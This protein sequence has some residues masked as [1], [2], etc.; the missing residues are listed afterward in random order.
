MNAYRIYKPNKQGN[1]SASEW[2][3]S[4][5]REEKFSPWKLFFSIAKQTGTDENGNNRFDWDNAI[6]V[7]MDV[8]DLCEILAVLED[9]QKEA[10][11]GGKIFHQYGNA[12]KIINFI[13]NEENNN[14]FIKVSHQNNGNVVS[15]QH[16][17]SIGEGCALKVLIEE[18]II[19]LTNWGYNNYRKNYT[20]KQMPSVP[21]ES[22]QNTLQQAI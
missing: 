20:P 2:Q 11:N 18:A 12:N 17:L 21:K 19:K 7:K 8:N 1:G 4:F 15:L 14:F 10:G 3:L 9:K 5:K 16:N 22:P 6:K 13:H